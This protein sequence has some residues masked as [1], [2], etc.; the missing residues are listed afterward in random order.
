MAALASPRG[1]REAVAYE[2]NLHD[3]AG[4]VAP[5]QDLLCE[6]V[7]DL[8]Q[9]RPLQGSGA[10]GRLVA[11]LD[12]PVLGRLRQLDPELPVRGQL[13]ETPQLDLDDAAQVFLRQRP[14]EDDV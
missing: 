3:A 11:E 4:R 14:K 12:E 9:D 2:V 1:E 10:E 8:L 13:L 7:L 6:R 5:A